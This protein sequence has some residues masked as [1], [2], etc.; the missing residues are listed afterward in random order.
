MRSGST[1]SKPTAKGSTRR[2]GVVQ[3]LSARG[4]ELQ[5][6]K[7]TAQML[8]GNFQFEPYGSDA[9]ADPQRQRGDF[10]RARSAGQSRQGVAVAR[11]S[12]RTGTSARAS[13]NS[14]CGS[15]TGAIGSRCLKAFETQAQMATVA[16]PTGG[17]PRWAPRMDSRQWAPLRL[18]R[19]TAPALPPALMAMLAATRWWPMPEA[20]LAL[21]EQDAQELEDWRAFV[22]SAGFT[23]FAP[24][25]TRS[26]APRHRCRRLTTC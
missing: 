23:R 12:C 20:P 4:A 14:S 7:F 15:T 19:R 5:D 25:L 3:T 9:S 17:R 2:S 22:T 6:G 26:G 1:R 8:K 24:T 10:N 21:S 11:G 16:T 13:S 18:R